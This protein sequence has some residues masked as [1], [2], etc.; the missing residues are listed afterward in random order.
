MVR[1]SNEIDA[2]FAAMKKKGAGVGGLSTKNLAVLAPSMAYQRRLKRGH[3]P[4]SAA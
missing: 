4:K 3:L 1:G 2:A